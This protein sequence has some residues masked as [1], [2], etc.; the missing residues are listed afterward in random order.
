MVS[1]VKKSTSRKQN[2]NVNSTSTLFEKKKEICKGTTDTG[3]QVA[4]ALNLGGTVTLSF[5]NTVRG[6]L[7]GD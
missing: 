1:S 3:L 4:F 7:S 5:T 6:P 2:I